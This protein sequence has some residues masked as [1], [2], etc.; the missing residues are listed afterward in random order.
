MN[1]LTGSAYY[2]LSVRNLNIRNFNVG[3]DLENTNGA[4]LYGNNVTGCPAAALYLDN[5]TLLAT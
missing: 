2:K 1:G 4:V 5:G 3:I